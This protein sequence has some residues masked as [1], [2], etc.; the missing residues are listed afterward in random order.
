MNPPHCSPAARCSNDPCH[1]STMGQQK[2]AWRRA[3]VLALVVGAYADEAGSGHS[4]HHLQKE[5]QQQLQRVMVADFVIENAIRNHSAQAQLLNQSQQKA[6]DCKVRYAAAKD[7]TAESQKQLQ[8]LRAQLKST[9][10]QLA[11]TQDKSKKLAR[12]VRAAEAEAEEAEAEAKALRSKADKVL[13]ER[14]ACVT[15]CCRYNGFLNYMKLYVLLGDPLVA[16]L[17]S[18]KARPQRLYKAL[19]GLV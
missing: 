7:S 6:A 14:Q 3:A 4:L 17:Y 9:Q 19:L 10:G 11:E 18:R 1:G 16:V 13:P 15:E 12:R 8:D 5:I 2:T